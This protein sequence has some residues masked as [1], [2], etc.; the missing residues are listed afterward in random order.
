L[1]EVIIRLV[2]VVPVYANWEDTVACLRDLAAQTNPRFRTLLADDGSPSPPPWEIAQFGFVDY[3]RH[4]HSGFAANCNRAAEEAISAGATHLLFLNND[5]AFGKD[6][7]DGWLRIAAAMPE[8]TVSP[9]IYWHSKPAKI[10][11][12]GGAQ[13]IWL[14]FLRPRR[15]YRVLAPVDVACGCALMTPARVW[16]EVGGFDVRYVT[17]FEDLDFTLRA[18]RLG[19]R[20]Y[21]DP[22]PG[23]R[24]WHKVGR[25]F[26]RTGS[27]DRRGRMFASSLIFIRAHYH[28]PTRYLCLALKAAHLLALIVLGLPDLPGRRFWKTVAE[29]LSK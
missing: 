17:Y 12:S 25:S 16:R 7:V 2:V 26:G 9:V 21:L 23:L 20:V 28:G 19:F 22:A 24:V 29:G 10:W 1:E 11:F 27:W 14:P 8:A 15:H 4:E 3:V 5:T 13:S 6:F 18:R